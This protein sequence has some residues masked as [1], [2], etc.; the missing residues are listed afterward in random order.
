MYKATSMTACKR[1]TGIFTISRSIS[2]GIIHIKSL[3]VTYP[4]GLDC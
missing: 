4:Q 3:R 1:D 2:A